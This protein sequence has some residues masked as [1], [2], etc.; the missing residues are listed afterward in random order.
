VEINDNNILSEH[1][2][3]PSPPRLGP[4]SA[5]GEGGMN[6][7]PPHK[8]CHHSAAAGRGGT[9]GLFVLDPPF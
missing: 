6:T 1:N 8:L 9:R 2:I 7:G 4:G 5:R 3:S